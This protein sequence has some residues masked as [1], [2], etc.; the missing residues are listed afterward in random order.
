MNSI[1]IPTI[2]VYMIANCNTYSQFIH[3]L[4]HTEKTSKY[5]FKKIRS[6]SYITPPLTTPAKIIYQLI[7]FIWAKE[8]FAYP[9]FLDQK[10]RRTPPFTVASALIYSLV[11][12]NTSSKSS[13]V[14]SSQRYSKGFNLPLK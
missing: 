8:P 1:Y 9:L 6:Y 3:R 12:S 13:T 2:L 10:K 11:S 14:I 7:F 4:I 5:L